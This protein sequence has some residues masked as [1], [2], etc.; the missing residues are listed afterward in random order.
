MTTTKHIIDCD[1]SPFVLDDSWSIEEHRQ[2]G[3]LE[4][5][6]KNISLYLTES[7]ETGSVARHELRKEFI[8]KP[9]LNTCVLDYLLKKCHLIPE[10]WKG[11]AILF[12]GTIYCRPDGVLC[13]LCLYWHFWRWNCYYC[14]L[15]FPDMDS[16]YPAAVLAS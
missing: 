6:I 5:D 14:R 1:A 10:E 4:W 16:G 13:V 11:K 2:G 12:W 3:Q 8:D 7:Q 15:D 9:V